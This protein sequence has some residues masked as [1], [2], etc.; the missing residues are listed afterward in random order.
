MSTTSQVCRVVTLGRNQVIIQSGSRQS[1]V[2]HLAC[3]CMYQCSRVLLKT[4]RIDFI[5]S[6]KFVCKNYTRS[7]V[8][9][10]GFKRRAIACE[11]LGN[12]G[13]KSA[14]L[15]KVHAIACI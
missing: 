4:D 6:Q 13:E 2:A 5:H 12:M 8:F 11:S 14:D 1:V 3:G 7:R 10:F 9:L 15:P